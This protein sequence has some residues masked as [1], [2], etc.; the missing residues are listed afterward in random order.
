MIAVF[1]IGGTGIKHALFDSASGALTQK[2][3]F[4]TVLD[5]GQA[6][7]DR[8]E[9]VVKDYQQTAPIEGIAFSVPGSVDEQTQTILS[10]NIID[11]FNGLNLS[12]YFKERLNLPVAVENDANSATLAEYMLGNGKG[13]KTLAV[14]TLGTGVGGGL[15]I[16]GALHRGNHSLGGE[17][18]FMFINGLRGGKPEEN[19]FSNDASTRA[20][21]EKAQD[22]FKRPV[23]G[24]ELFD[25]ADQSNTTA[26]TVLEKYY[27][28]LAMGI[29][30]ICYIVAPD[31]VLIGG[32]V[33][34]QPK[35]IENLKEKITALT[36]S[37]SVDLNDIIG[38]D[39]CK[40]LND[41][42]LVGAGCSFVNRY[43]DDC[44]K[45]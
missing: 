12:D 33:S 44:E 37:F 22:A 25:L 45:E 1:D 40:F 20:L 39:R 9:A 14:V 18:G 16:N 41:A 42:G 6:N 13:S 32:A 34:Q 38:I 24:V 43:N 27:M 31:R 35:L 30:N 26:E 23:S 21:E 10:G 2:G 8:I 19:I 4:G 7:L 3:R 17:Y 28:D 36:P 15:I 11:G 29:Y 5:D